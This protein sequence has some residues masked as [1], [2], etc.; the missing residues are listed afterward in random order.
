MG[1]TPFLMGQGFARKLVTSP[2]QPSDTTALVPGF[3]WIDVPRTRTLLFDVYHADAAARERPFGWL[4][5]PSEG[6][7]TV[8]RVGYLSFG[9]IANPARGDSGKG[10]VPHPVVSPDDIKRANDLATKILKQTTFG[11]RGGE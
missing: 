6:I 1:L 5:I 11:R 10:P 9:E 3:G 7:L 8:Y 2:I 4:D